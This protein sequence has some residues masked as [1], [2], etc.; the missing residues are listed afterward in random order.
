MKLQSRSAQEKEEEKRIDI[1]LQ[2]VV[3]GSTQTTFVGLKRQKALNSHLDYKQLGI[4]RKQNKTIPTIC[5]DSEKEINL[6][7]F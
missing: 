5:K 2:P 3:L 6:I 7:Q 1:L 4:I